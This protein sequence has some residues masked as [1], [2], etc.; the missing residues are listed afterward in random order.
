MPAVAL[1]NS[2]AFTAVLSHGFVAAAL[3]CALLPADEW[4]GQ[5]GNARWLPRRVQALGVLGA[6]RV[7]RLSLRR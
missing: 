2:S 7:S 3:V 5:G 6:D 1:T 4:P